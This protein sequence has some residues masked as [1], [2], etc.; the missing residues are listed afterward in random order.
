MQNALSVERLTA[1]LTP[2]TNEKTWVAALFDGDNDND[3]D[4]DGDDDADSDECGGDHD[5]HWEESEEEEN[6]KG[7]GPF[8]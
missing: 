8:L 7:S 2:K 4:E 6:R 3:E 5:D 1:V